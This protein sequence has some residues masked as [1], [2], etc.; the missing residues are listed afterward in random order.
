L[1]AKVVKSAVMVR[2]SSRAVILAN[3]AINILL[4]GALQQMFSVLR[5]LQIMVH[6]II[7]NV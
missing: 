6:L 2:D 3:F 7:V 1:G 5:K 4:A